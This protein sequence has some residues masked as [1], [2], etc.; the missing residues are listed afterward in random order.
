MTVEE[1]AA[2]LKVSP[3]DIVQL[4]ESG[5]LKARKIGTTYRISRAAIEEFMKGG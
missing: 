1:A 5:Q 4:I 3:E 2:Y